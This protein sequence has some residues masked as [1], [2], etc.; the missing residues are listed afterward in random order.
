MIEGWR[1]K[2][3]QAEGVIA[4]AAAA[5]AAALV[6]ELGIVL[7]DGI[8]AGK[9]SPA[10]RDIFE[11]AALAKG[12]GKASK[13]GILYL[14]GRIDARPKQVSTEE[15]GQKK[16][17]QETTQVTRVVAAQMGVK[18]DD[19]ELFKTDR[20]AWEAKQIAKR[21]GASAR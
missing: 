12:G 1:E 19:V 21:P 17:T 16:Q 18:M 13:E 4:A 5:Q 3:T 6:T 2:S 10:D 8:K 20:P 11:A 9:V 7:D 15:T 14:R